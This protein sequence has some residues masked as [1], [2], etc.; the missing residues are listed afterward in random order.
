MV[1]IFSK[2]RAFQ[3]EVCLRSLLN[4]CRDVKEIPIRVVWTASSANHRKSYAILRESLG[5]WPNIEFVEESK[6]RP[7]LI[8]VLGR[9]A[10][11]SWQAG[12]V[13]LVEQRFPSWLRKLALPL[14]V[15]LLNPA[16]VV[17]YAVDDTIFLR[18]FSF[19]ECSSHLLARSDALAFSLRLGRGLTRFYMGSRDQVVPELTPVEKDSDICEFRWAEA[20]GDFGYP[21]EIS[22]SLLKSKLILVRLLRKEWRTPNTLEMAVAKMSGRYRK[23]HPMVLTFAEPR[24]VCVPLNMVQKD[25][26]ENRHGGQERY[27]V[28]SLCEHFLSGVRADLSGLDKASLNS[29]HAEIELLPV[30]K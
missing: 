3:L 19:A 29:V 15:Q 2:D 5:E 22:S 18:P 24:A 25:F 8:I 27:H 26:T 10:R 21:L 30:G 16:P 1:I 28:D 11:Q 14:M 13:R 9:L 17:L 7:D 20:D 12:V 4:H 23:T 6:F